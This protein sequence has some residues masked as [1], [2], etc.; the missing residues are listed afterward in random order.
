MHRSTQ[1][2]ALLDVVIQVSNSDAGHGKSR[3]ITDLPAL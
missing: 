2:Q 3:F 1:P